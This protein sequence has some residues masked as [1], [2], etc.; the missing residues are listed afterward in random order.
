MRVIDAIRVLYEEAGGDLTMERATAVEGLLVGS[1]SPHLEAGLRSLVGMQVHGE[2]GEAQ[3][4]VERFLDEP[5][6][7][8]WLECATHGI[9]GTGRRGLLGLAALPCPRLVPM[10][11]VPAPCGSPLQA[12]EVDLD[13]ARKLIEGL[14]ELA[15]HR[16]TCPSTAL[17]GLFNRTISDD[18]E[19]GL[20]RL[21]QETRMM[22]ELGR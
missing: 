20:T 2:A 11:I 4:V 7:L 5:A 1:S 10:G 12:R 14:T 17:R 15:V 18:C 21:L 22:K 8:V 16:E 13:L 6:E 9:V 3:R 19:C